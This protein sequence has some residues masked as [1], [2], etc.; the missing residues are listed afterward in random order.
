MFSPNLDKLR[1]CLKMFGCRLLLMIFIVSRVFLIQ[2]LFFCW[3]GFFDISGN[4]F[5]LF[6][7]IIVLVLFGFMAYQQL[8]VIYYQIHCHTYKQ[9][10]FKQ[11]RLA[12]E[13]FF[14]RLLTVKWQTALFQTID[15]ELGPYPVRPLRVRVILGAKRY[16]TFSKA[17]ALLEPHHQIFLCHRQDTH[18]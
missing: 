12:L 17:R 3:S 13:Q 1:V 14:F 18:L 2:S 4:S 9:W 5:G 7:L 11:S 16:F 15:P 8:W 6:L 10:Y